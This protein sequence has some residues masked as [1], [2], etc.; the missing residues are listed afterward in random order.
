MVT[1]VL[2]KNGCRTSLRRRRLH[3]RRPQETSLNRRLRRHASV[4]PA[5][6]PLEPSRNCHQR[7]RSPLRQDDVGRR[8]PLRR[9]E[10]GSLS[11]SEL[12]ED[13]PE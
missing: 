1:G 11:L 6:L 5:E 2:G 8:D 4:L 7:G 12:H 9:G 13:A 10:S 3:E